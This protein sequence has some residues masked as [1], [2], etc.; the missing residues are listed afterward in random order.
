MHNGRMVSREYVLA[1][2]RRTAAENDGKPLGRDRFM[3]VTGIREREWEGFWSRWGDAVEEAGFARNAMTARYSDDHL[4]G[5]LAHETRRL[6][7]PPTNG[8]RHVRHVADPTFPDAKV[9]D[10][11]PRAERLSRLTA[12]CEERPGWAD[13]VAI[14]QATPA[15]PVRP[16]QEGRPTAEPALGQVYLIRSGRYHKIGRTNAFARRMRE[17][18]TALAEGRQAIHII[19]TDD[20]VGIEAYWHNRFK[21]RRRGDTEWFELTAQD[22]AA[23]KRRKFM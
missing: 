7:H 5:L 11:W 17:L 13:V 8:E 12:Y 9:F 2:I 3:D 18:D 4:L 6:G 16:L 14:L 1:E 21:E 19:A 10:R 20:P 22:I 23:F 15:T